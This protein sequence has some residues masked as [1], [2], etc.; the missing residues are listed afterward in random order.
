MANLQWRE[1]ECKDIKLRRYKFHYFVP[2][3]YG[4]SIFQQLEIKTRD[5]AVDRQ[6][7]LTV[8]TGSY[9]V[10]TLDDVNGNPVELWLGKDSEG[11]LLKRLPVPK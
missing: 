11:N 9:G 5:I 8:Y 3:S 4:P 6:A 7:R 2:A 1:L 10:T